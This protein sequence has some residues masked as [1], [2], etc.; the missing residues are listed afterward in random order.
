MRYSL[1][2]PHVLEKSDERRFSS[3]P[4]AAFPVCSYD[5]DVGGLGAAGVVGEYPSDRFCRLFQ[6][7]FNDHGLC[8][9]FN[10]VRL[11]S[12]DGQKEDDDVQNCPIR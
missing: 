2:P 4:G 5:G 6:T 1:H 8:Y 11:G 12:I 3:V 10:N 9:T 7:T